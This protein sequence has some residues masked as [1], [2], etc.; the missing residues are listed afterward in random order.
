L[1]IAGPTACGK[2]EA[3]LRVAEAVPAEIVSA[4]SMQIYEYMDIG[5]AKPTPQQRAQVPMHLVD[6]ADP[7][8]PYTVADFQRQ[9]REAIVDIHGRARL[10][11]LCGGTGLYLRAVLQHLDFPSDAGPQQEQIRA[12]LHAEAEAN[13]STAL[14]RRLAELDP[15]AA[16][17]IEPNDTRRIVRALEVIEATGELFSVQQRIDE[18]PAVDYNSICFVLTRP[19]S[20]LYAAIERRVDEMLQMGWLAEV[21][22]LRQ[23]GCSRPAQ[24]MQA[25]G[26]RH[27]LA[28]LEGEVGYKET[29][30]LIKRDTRRFAKRQLTWFRSD[31]RANSATDEAAESTVPPCRSALSE[32]EGQSGNDLAPRRSGFQPDAIAFEWLE[33][34]APHEFEHCVERIIQAAKRL[35]RP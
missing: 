11:V 16:R 18:T 8:Q 10:P 27:L 21:E 35:Y 9:A 30:R 12:R 17:K 13:G 26:Y 24:A 32:A 1:V 28:H 6:F 7:R 15:A 4:D 19:R 20:Q 34:A 31:A 3:A 29:V 2:T 22:A 23:R 25:I 14:H 33:W 5:T